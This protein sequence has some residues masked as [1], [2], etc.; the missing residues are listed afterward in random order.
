MLQRYLLQKASKSACRPRSFQAEDL[1]DLIL[2][3]LHAL[4]CVVADP[5]P[6]NH[7]LRPVPVQGAHYVIIDHFFN[8]HI[9]VTHRVPLPGEF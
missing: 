1:L 2:G 6:H 9:T 3:D 7:G 4:L 5:P 8:S